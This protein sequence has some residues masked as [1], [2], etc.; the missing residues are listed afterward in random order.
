MNEILGGNTDKLKQMSNSDIIGIDKSYEPITIGERGYT[1]LSLP[2][3][4]PYIFS[5]V[6][7]YHTN[8][9]CFTVHRSGTRFW[10]SLLVKLYQI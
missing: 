6:I 8:D 7:T 2:Y 5:S 3:G 9:Q 10:L 4:A 1:Q